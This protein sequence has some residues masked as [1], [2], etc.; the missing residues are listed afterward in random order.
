MKQLKKP[1][2]NHNSAKQKT[3][4]NHS[5]KNHN[6]IKTKN[7]GFCFLLNHYNTMMDIIWTACDVDR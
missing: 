3:N 2:Q 6:K 4:Q 1:Q 5:D 7:Y